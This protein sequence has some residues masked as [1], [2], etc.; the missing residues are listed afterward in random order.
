MERTNLSIAICALIATTPVN[1]LAQASPDAWAFEA[2]PY[3]WAA[4]SSGW[5]RIGARTPAVNLD[6]SFSNVWRNL[7]FGAMGTF[8]ARK[9]RWGI[10]VDAVYV[11]LSKTS[12]PLA[13]GDLGT[14]R[15]KANQAIVQAAGAYRVL[16]SP[17]TPV[18]VLAGVRYTHLDANTTLSSSRLLPNGASHSDSVGWTDGFAGIRAAFAWT[19]RWSVVGYADVG[20]GGTKLS[21]QFLGSINYS[22]SKTFV[23]KAGYRVISMNYDKPEFLYDIRTAGPFIGVGIRF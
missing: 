5:A 14:V 11:D 3:F 12:D 23:A 15:L 4:G 9:G 19:E 2:T 20:A 7:D 16:D 1:A 21:W 18:D 13:G 17:T 6:A 10:I 8:E 22:I